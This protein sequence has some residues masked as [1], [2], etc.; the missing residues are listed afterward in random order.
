MAP[1]KPDPG[2][3]SA[4]PLDLDA[5]TDLH[6]ASAFRHRW[7]LE[8][9]G[10]DGPDL[11]S[12]TAR[13]SAFLRE[14][15][16]THRGIL[17]EIDGRTV[18]VGWVVLIDRLPWP[19]DDAPRAGLLQAVYVDADARGHGAGTGLI[20][21]LLDEARERGLKY[22]LVNP[23][24][25]SEPLYRRLGFGGAEPPLRLDLRADGT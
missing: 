17:A 5:P 7:W 12:F 9:R 16:P 6:V 1:P 23:T 14:R 19:D 18:G 11:E 3:I 2:R 8:D 15:G 25:R 24:E 10:G 13:F 21:A 20:T 22:V 4:R